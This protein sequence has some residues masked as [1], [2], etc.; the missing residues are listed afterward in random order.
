MFF[1]IY[2]K[3]FIAFLKKTYKLWGLDFPLYFGYNFKQSGLF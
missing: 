2:Y 3:E 1:L